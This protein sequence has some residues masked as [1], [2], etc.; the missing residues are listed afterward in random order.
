MKRK[1][2][3]LLRGFCLT[4]VGAVSLSLFSQNVTVTGTV[5]D[6]TGEPL[7]GV[8]VQVTGTSVGTVTDMNGNF[9][10][11]NVPGGATL[12]VSY[13]GMRTQSIALN[14]RTSLRVVLHEDTE[15]L[16][17]VVV[18]GYGQMRRSDLTGAVVS[19]TDAAIKRSVPTSIDQVLQGRAAGVQIQANSGTPGA[20]SAIRI[21]GI[22]SLNAT[23]QPIFVIDGVIVD[24][25]TNSESSNPLSSINPSDIVS[26]DILKDA[27]ASAIYGARASNGV[28]MITTKRGSKGEAI[29]TYDGYT[30]W[31]EMPSQLDM[32]NLREYATHHNERAELGLVNKSS[33]F[34]RPD[35]LGEGTNWQDELFRKALM[36][37]H[38]L[39]VSG[40]N[41][42]TT[43]AISGGYL[44]QEGIA[45]GSGFRRLSLRANVDTHIKS[46]LR[47]GVNFSF[48]ESRQDVGT[49]NNT[50]MSALLQQPT[51]AVTSPDGSYDGPDDVWMPD[52]PVGLTS[53]RT[54]NNI[55]TNF[56][57]NT[58]LEATITKGLTYRSEL[59]NDFNFNKFYYYQ[60]DYQFG[61]K[62]S[63]TRTSRWTKTDSKYWS[64][65][66]IL[67]YDARVNDV[68]AINLMLGQEM[69]QADW[70]TQN[71]TVTGFLTNTTP[72]LSAGDITTSTA[73]G[74]RISNSIASG[75]GRAFYSY[76][77]RY[78]ATATLRR[79]GSSKFATGNKW[80]W[81][82]S[83]A[84]AW[85]TSQESFLVDNS[86]IDNMKFR[87]GWGATGNQNVNDYAYMA[88][89][90]FRTTPWGTGVLTGNTA[91]PD[92]TWE[93]T[94]S[95]NLGID[96]GLFNNR[97]EFIGDV[98]YKE[99]KNLLLQLPLPA[100]L[101][102]SGQGAAANPWG[103]IGSLENKGIELTLNTT[104]IT[105][106]D[107]QWTTN[108][109]Y[110][111]NR[112]KVLELDTDNS[113]IEKTYQP[114]STNYIVTKTTVGEPIGQFWG[115]K[116]IGRFDEPTDFYYKDGEGN[117][118]Q[119]AIPEGNS[120][121]ENSTWIGD[122]IFEDRNGDGLINNEDATF[123]G[124]PEPKFTYGIGNTFSYKGLDL[125]IFFSGS[126]GNQALNLARFRIEDPRSN[127]NILRSSL[128]YA[129]VEMI[130]PNGPANDYRNL[131]VVG[132]SPT[133]PALQESDANN[134]YTRVSNL[135]IEDASFLRLQN[136][137][138]GYTLP[139]GW[140]SKIY[141][142][143]VRIYANIQNLYTWTKYK[144]LDPEIGAMYGD[145][146]MNG[147]DYG[148]YPSPRIYTVGLNV[149]F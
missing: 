101:G 3:N 7:I 4:L 59:S 139:K 32:L 93:T 61:I 113:S 78:L 30:G 142:D 79:D 140:I 95:Y 111:L 109:V 117:V 52:N 1:I 118:K 131:H 64:W 102:S 47:G 85:R 110:S 60:P 73:T 96:L 45:L 10:L 48:A 127:A 57:F 97:V 5:S 53:I 86:T 147:V 65:R 98:Y 16:E 25:S 70:E 69:S 12:E 74:S 138:V 135:L 40:G 22:N 9:S 72:D 132:G 36:T 134:N 121:A 35:L 55:K 34:V 67:T 71:G 94:Y 88:L 128:D 56:R 119:V 105:N 28:I 24:S 133:M 136:I 19:V 23:N 103:N 115:Y 81:F 63:D 20:S 89:L 82:P 6:A 146:L 14:G 27:S 124:N 107:F 51:V 84:L 18:V 137:S 106:R 49:D 148:R 62:T 2:S 17:E 112:N 108:L 58:Y 122:Y 38:N 116:V 29:V 31:Q 33:A 145:A 141:L 130:D 91:N 100:Y 75:F 43:Y 149:S 83:L 90:S 114:G 126:Y 99:T 54:N 8:T 104:N 87:F 129:K 15:L 92:L 21:R 50:I 42:M 46:W 123:I 13:V 76:D 125:T 144:G 68:H 66:N 44:N 143:N 80:G 26:M 77:E 41:E 37:S 39:S 11:P 120:I